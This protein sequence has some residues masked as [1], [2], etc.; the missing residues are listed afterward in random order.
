MVLG[1]CISTSG[2]Y[3]EINIPNKTPEVLE[4]IRKKYKNTGIQYQGKLQDSLNPEKYISIF[5]CISDDDEPNVHVFPSPFNEETYTCNIVV[6]A[7][8]N[9]NQDEYEKHATSYINLTISDYE[10]LYGGWSFDT[11]SVD[12]DNLSIASSISEVVEA[13]Q[14]Q[15]V[16]PLIINTKDVFVN[17]PIREKSIEV[18]T[19][20]VGDVSSE[21]E[22]NILKFV[23]EI[24][25]QIGI[26]IDWNNK[27]FWNSYV[28]K[29]VSV[30]NL[31][32]KNE[33]WKQKFL[34]KEINCHAFVNL[35]P[36]EICPEKWSMDKLIEMEKKFYSKRIT[37]SIILY[38]KMCK[39]KSQCDY[40]QM[41]T[42][43]ADEPMTTF[44]TC[45]ECSS[46]WKF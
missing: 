39:K 29:C 38:C 6:L 36:Q 12:E 27:V 11:E 7:S 5:A 30:N 21:L 44:V 24:S 46:R 31:L 41:Q 18:F 19:E 4:W 40:Y 22:T 25:K 28:S 14:V 16:K 3:S 1:V 20:T 10:I 35:H 8:L 45:S 2:V 17:C 37:A 13:K 43:S 34:N 26:D 33:T 15:L 42:R 23:I 9:E 32:T